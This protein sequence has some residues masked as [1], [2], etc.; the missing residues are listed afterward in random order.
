MMGNLSPRRDGAVDLAKCLAIC[1]VLVIHCASGHFGNYEVGANRWLAADF[2]GSV[3]RW[4]VPVFLMCSGALMNDP[5]RDV[6]LKKLF[7][8]YLLRLLAALAVW[9]AFYEAFRIVAFP[10]GE[11]L[12]A[13]LAEAAENLFYC[14]TYYHLYYFY[15][16]FALY[17]TLP[18]T[19]LIARHASDGELRYVLLLWFLAGGVIR[20][21]KFFWPLNQMRDYSP[22]FFSI[23]ACV[24]CPG[25]GLGGWYMRRHPPENC[26]GGLL[27]FGAGFA[28]TALGTWRRSAAA[29]TLDQFYLD[30]F[31]LFSLLMGIGVFRLCQWAA[32]RWSQ[33]PG[34][35]RFLSAASFCVYLVHPVFQHYLTPDNFLAMPVYWAVPLQAAALLALSLAA[36]LLLRRVPWVNRWLI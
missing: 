1:A 16:A 12:G 32:G 28:V 26:A 3:S 27:L 20:F 15:F 11:P 5:A 23:P 29:G 34:P 2:Y 19:R 14:K 8:K 10:N 33:P 18:L 13:R 17:L 22:V 30:A 21:F 7:S 24:M 31:G 25:L 36:Y 35:V 6:P 9:A 4:A